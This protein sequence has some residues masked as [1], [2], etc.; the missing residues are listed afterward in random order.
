MLKIVRVDWF[1]PCFAKSGWMDKDDF[2]SFCD[3]P[4]NSSTSIGILAK[5]DKDKIV[6]LQSIGDNCVADA[7][8]INRASIIKMVTIG[9]INV[10]LLI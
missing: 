9:K 5:E 2:V 8:K 7:I 1:D 10:A 3:S 4:P 6:I